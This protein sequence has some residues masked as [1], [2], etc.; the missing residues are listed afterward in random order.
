MSP[1]QDPKANRSLSQRP[2]RPTLFLVSIIQEGQALIDLLGLSQVAEQPF[3][4]FSTADQQVQLIVTGIGPETARHATLYALHDLLLN[5]MDWVNFGIAGHK[6]HPLGSLFQISSFA[7]C[8]STLSSASEES[9]FAHFPPI[10]APD[11]RAGFEVELLITYPHFV[12]DY[13]SAGLVDMEG[14]SIAQ[15]LGENL[16]L[17]RLMSFKVISD[18]QDESLLATAEG[19]QHLSSLL[20]SHAKTIILSLSSP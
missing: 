13:P 17:G 1:P 3:R 11:I 10:T 5:E 6:S 14:Y 20:F 16:M 19:K 15:T 9:I 18:H 2:F 12:E 7:H 8:Q 4:R